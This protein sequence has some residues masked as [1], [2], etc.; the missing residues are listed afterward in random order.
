MVEGQSGPLPGA[1]P[2]SDRHVH[3]EVY[4]EEAI[5]IAKEHTAAAKNSPMA[6]H[7]GNV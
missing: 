6:T 2:E 4:L 7:Q 3:K 5:Q 1:V